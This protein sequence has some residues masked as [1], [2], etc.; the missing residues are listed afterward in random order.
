[1]PTAM[2]RSTSCCAGMNSLLAMTRRATETRRSSTPS[3]CGKTS[4]TNTQSTKIRPS[5][6]LHTY[7]FADAHIANRGKDQ[8]QFISP[9]KAALARALR[10]RTTTDFVVVPLDQMFMLWSAANPRLTNGEVIGADQRDA[11]GRAEGDDDQ[12]RARQY[13]E[14]ATK[15]SIEPG[16]LADFVILD[17]NPLKVKPM[18]IKDIKIVETIKE[19]A[20]IWPAK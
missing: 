16:K 1:M 14:D 10:R 5:F 20:T 2:R 3:S 11:I 15:G 9:M 19:G 18:E 7:Y 17:K 6:P 13:G 8:A 4:S 12:W